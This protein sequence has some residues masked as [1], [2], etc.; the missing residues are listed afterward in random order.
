MTGVVDLRDCLAELHAIR[1]ET[2]TIPFNISLVQGL[3]AIDR[4]TEG[5]VLSEETIGS[6]ET[7]GA[8]SY[9]PELLRLKGRLQTTPG[10]MEMYFRQSIELSRRQGALAWELRAATDLASLLANNGE[11]ESAAAL[12]RPV[13]E[14]FAEGLDTPDLQAAE[15]RLSGLSGLRGE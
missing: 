7:N 9:L 12:L 11:S 1:Y 5:L 3:M 4:S 8:L 6:A 15:R 13:F 2:L 10:S 14:Q